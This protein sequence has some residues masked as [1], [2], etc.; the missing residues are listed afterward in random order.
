M[1]N[2]YKDFGAWLRELRVRAGFLSQS[3]V[4]VR[5]GSRLVNQ[6]KLSHIERGLNKNP[7]PDLLR[8]LSSLYKRPYR[9]LIARWVEARFGVDLVESCH[10]R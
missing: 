10:A 6:G 8:A 3:N 2:P 1:S 4:E 7:S 5:G 9:E